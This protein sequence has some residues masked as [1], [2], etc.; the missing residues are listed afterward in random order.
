MCLHQHR[1]T[2]LSNALCHD[3]H[4]LRT[5]AETLPSMAA[6]SWRLRHEAISFQ[7]HYNLM[8]TPWFVQSFINPNVVCGACL[9]KNEND[10]LI[11]DMKS[12]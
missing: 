2:H 1:Q 12:H 11:E 3:G 8:E 9:D 6:T 4:D 10:I 5:D 7:L